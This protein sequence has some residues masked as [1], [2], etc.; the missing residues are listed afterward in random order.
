MHSAREKSHYDLLIHTPTCSV[1]KRSTSCGIC[2]GSLPERGGRGGTAGQDD[3]KKEILIGGTVY[4]GVKVPTFEILSGVLLPGEG[5]GCVGHCC[6][7]QL[8]HQQQQCNQVISRCMRCQP[9]RQL[10]P[11]QQAYHAAICIALEAYALVPWRGTSVPRRVH[12]QAG[13]NTPEQHGRELW[14][15]TC[16]DRTGN[17]GQEGGAPLAASRTP[18]LCVCVGC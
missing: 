9:P 13:R 3:R 8:Q 5:G 1:R 7:E 17:A 4:D 10:S 12:Q 15:F 16:S 6:T 2:V 11:L 14:Q 18:C